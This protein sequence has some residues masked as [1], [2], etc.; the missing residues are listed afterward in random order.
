M[1]FNSLAFLVF[2]PIVTA[3]YFATPHRRRWIVLLA[4]SS[5]FYMCFIPIY[6]VILFGTIVVDYV[7]ALLIE[8]AEGRRRK[9]YLAL[10]IVAN[11][12]VLA[13]FKYY[14]FLNHN[15]EALVTACD[16]KYSIPD[17]TIVLPIGLSFHT[18]QAMSYTMEVYRGKQT[19]E[20]HI[21][22]YAV[23]VMFY[24]QLVAGPIERPQNLLHQFR[25]PHE[26]SDKNVAMGARLMLLGFFK[27]VVVADRLAFIVGKIYGDVGQYHGLALWIATFLFSFQ[28]YCDFSGYSDIALGA[29]RVMGF[30]LTNN[31]DRPYFSRSISEFWKRWHISLSTWFKD[32]LYVP[33]GGNR[34]GR[35][36]WYANLFIVFVVSGIWHGANWTFIIWGA[37]HGAYLVFAIVSQPA[38]DNL[39][40]ALG[41]RRRPR[42][43]RAWQMT[44]VFALTSFAWIF[45]R[46]NTLNDALYVCRHLFDFAGTTFT[47]RGL[48]AG[49][50][51]TGLGIPYAS[52]ITR[53]MLAQSVALIGVLLSLDVWQERRRI[54]ELLETTSTWKRWSLYYAMSFAIVLLGFSSEYQFI[55]FQF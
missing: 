9:A 20:R 11:V 1:L 50:E 45:F 48:M 21:G 4:S 31:F 3:L 47:V 38:R 43:H 37:L 51:L 55:Y 7:A 39:T 13:V 28:I 15:I 10:S 18:F 16:L 54:D 26:L 53:V 30:D 19:A 34:V 22:H 52:G 41:L 14:N 42:L 35:G 2:F 29:A 6:I 12:G 40:R 27:K 32:Y 49:P 25:E 17:L 46:A 36:R 5:Y 8:S 44:L 23:Y 33:L 24:P